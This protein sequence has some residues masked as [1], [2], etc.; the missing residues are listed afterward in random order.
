MIVV[1]S[2]ANADDDCLAFLQEKLIQVGANRSAAGPGPHV[3]YYDALDTLTGDAGYT[4]LGYGPH[5]AGKYA[6][7]GTSAERQI[8][9]TKFCWVRTGSDMLER[10]QDGASSPSFVGGGDWDPTLSTTINMH[11]AYTGDWQPMK[12]Y[13]I[14]LTVYGF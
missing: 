12:I 13:C 9:R 14:K 5:F 1:E 3:A 11:N 10:F 4:T 6:P 7:G 8:S 2:H